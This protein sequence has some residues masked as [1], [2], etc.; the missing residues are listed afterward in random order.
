MSKLVELSKELKETILN[1]CHFSIVSIKVEYEQD[2]VGLSNPI[3]IEIRFKEIKKDNVVFISSIAELIRVLEQYDVEMKLEYLYGYE[4][5]STVEVFLKDGD[6][7]GCVVF[8][9]Y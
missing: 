1:T 6:L 4:N 9:P 8:Q 5:I 2:S 3:S 7:T